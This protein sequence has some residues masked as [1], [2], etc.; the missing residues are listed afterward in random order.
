MAPFLICVLMEAQTA[1]D[2]R[3][4]RHGP[5]G[6]SHPLRGIFCEVGVDFALELRRLQVFQ[7]ISGGF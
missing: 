6:F 5:G 1:G 4:E 2:A 3:W 7:Q